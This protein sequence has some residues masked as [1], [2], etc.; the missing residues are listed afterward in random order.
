MKSFKPMSKFK[1]LFSFVCLLILA[2]S[3][4]VVH[5]ARQSDLSPQ[6]NRMFDAALAIWTTCTATLPTLLTRHSSK[7]N[8]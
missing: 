1:F 5:L 8:D 2:S 7:D 4:A 3:G 6:Q